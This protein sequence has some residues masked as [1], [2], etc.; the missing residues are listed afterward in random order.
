[1]INALARLMGRIYSGSMSI[2]RPWKV[3]VRAGGKRIVDEY[4]KMVF[5]KARGCPKE[6]YPYLFL[7]EDFAEEKFGITINHGIKRK[8]LY[9]DKSYILIKDWILRRNTFGVEFTFGLAN[10]T[11]DEELRG[12]CLDLTRNG[13]KNARKDGIWRNYDVL[14]IG[15]S[16]VHLGDRMRFYSI[17]RWFGLLQR[18]N[19]E[20]LWSMLPP[21]LQKIYP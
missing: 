12:I 11:E 17:F 13:L 21:F 16:K 3:E 10:I 15:T 19:H 20:F 2:D 18:Y 8:R 5:K 6:L 1:M 14:E 4:L 9:T 7:C